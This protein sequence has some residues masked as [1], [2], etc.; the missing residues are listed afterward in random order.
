VRAEVKQRELETELSIAQASTDLIATGVLDYSFN[1][2]EEDATS[3]RR[4]ATK[5]AS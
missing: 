3:G 5:S 4:P 2:D 1:D